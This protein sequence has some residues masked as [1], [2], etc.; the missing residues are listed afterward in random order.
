MSQV[1]KFVTDGNEKV[2]GLV[3]AGAMLDEGFM[4]EV[5]A[6][7][8]QQEGEKKC[9]QLCS[10]QP[11]FT[12]WWRNEKIVKNSSRSQK[13]S[14]PLWSRKD[15]NKGSNGMVRK[16]QQVSMHEVWKSSKKQEK[17]TGPTYLSKI[18]GKWIKRH[19]GG[20]DMVRRNGQAGRSLDFGAE[21][22]WDMRDREWD[23]H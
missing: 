16:C 2:A 10:M 22:A 1:E 6:K 11:D 23:Q 21:K 9:T 13:K 19:W 3:K 18:L 8:M 14:G 4:A 15:R 7:T 17:R 20:H 12:V 5:R